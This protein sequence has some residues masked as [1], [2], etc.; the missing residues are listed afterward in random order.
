MAHEGG[1]RV[2]VTGGSRGIGAAVCRAFAAGGDV[3]AV[4]CSSNRAAAEAVVAGLPGDGHVVVQG[5]LRDAAAVQAFVDDAAARLGGLDVLVNNAGV[6][7]YHHVEDDYETWQL[8]WADILGVNLVGAANAAYCALKHLPRDGSARIVNV[9]SRGAFRGEPDSPAYAASKAGLTALGQ[10]LAKALGGTGV[11]VT[12][13]APGFVETDMAAFLLEGPEGDA[14]RGQSPLNRV[15]TP[16]EIADAVL[17]LASP[18]AQ[19][20]TGTVLDLNGASHLRL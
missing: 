6:Y 16:E 13:V 5:D 9:G 11:S 10:S 8:A 7:S 19:W 1:R 20:A 15:A 4:H 14:I 17:Y 2:L 18:G 12:T 3:V